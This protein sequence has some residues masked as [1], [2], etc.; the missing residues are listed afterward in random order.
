MRFQRRCVHA[1]VYMVAATTAFCLG[2]FAGTGELIVSQKDRMF[3]PSSISL[4][5]G[6][7]VTIVNDDIGILHHAYV[8]SE[9]FN[10]DSGDQKPGSRSKVVFSVPGDFLVLCGIHPKMK[11][12]VHV[13]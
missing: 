1:F 5:Q 13:R 4:H 3:A 7:A 6:E 2:A 11:L 10:Y 9:T 12:M 8:E